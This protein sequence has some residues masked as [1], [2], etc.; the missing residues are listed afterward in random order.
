MTS[1]LER[2]MEAA[3]DDHALLSVEPATAFGNYNRPVIEPA[4]PAS[5]DKYAQPPLDDSI[6]ALMIM[7]GC[8][9]KWCVNFWRLESK[10]GARAHVSARNNFEEWQDAIK[11]VTRRT[12]TR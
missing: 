4:T 2:L 12:A 3:R 6:T 8:T 1:P 7:A 11:T 10:A 9:A 5:T